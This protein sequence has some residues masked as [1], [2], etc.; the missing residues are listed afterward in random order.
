FAVYLGKY[1]TDSDGDG[2]KAYID[3]GDCNDHDATISPGA[4]EIAG[5]FKDDDCD[6][7]VDEDAN[8]NASTD[9]L[10]HDGDGQTIAQGDCDD[11]NAMIKKGMPEICGDGLDNDCDGVADR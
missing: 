6:G 5:N 11:T 7:K 3:K 4:A 10:D 2:K 1:V 8:G 9:A